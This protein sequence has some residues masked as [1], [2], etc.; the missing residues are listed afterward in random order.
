[1][2]D[3]QQLTLGLGFQ[4][5]AA[6]KAATLGRSL[7]E[8]VEMLQGIVRRVSS[9]AALDT[10][11]YLRRGGRLSRVQ[12][13]VGNLLRIKSL[14]L[15][16]EA[17]LTLEKTRTTRGVL[18][19][20]NQAVHDLAPLENLAVVHAGARERADALWAQFRHFYAGD[21]YSYHDPGDPCHRRA[22]RAGGGGPGVRPGGGVR[23]RSSPFA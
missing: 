14:L 2:F 9:F 21:R 20:L 16:Y 23:R 15:L 12:A 22:H 1:V 5:L 10:L 19:R 13:S 17:E 7:G 4:A 11:E 18:A 6:A 8:I 3:S